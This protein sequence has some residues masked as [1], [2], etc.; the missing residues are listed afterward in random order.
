MPNTDF[1]NETS[2]PKILTKYL[3]A[4]MCNIC[5]TTHQNSDKQLTVEKIDSMRKH[6]RNMHLHTY[7]NSEKVILKTENPRVGGS[8]P[9]LATNILPKDG[10]PEAVLFRCGQA[11]N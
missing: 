9:S 10:F 8:T 1:R 3:H 6:N 7:P 5:A 2:K 4:Q 11:V